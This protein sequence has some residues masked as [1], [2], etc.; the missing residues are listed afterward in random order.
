MGLDATDCRTFASM[1]T[2]EENV[3][4]IGVELPFVGGYDFSGVV[5]DKGPEADCFSIGDEAYGRVPSGGAAAEYV[6]VYQHYVASKPKSLS[7]GQAATIPIPIQTAHW[8]LVEKGHLQAGQYLL[9][10]GGGGSVGSVSV[11]LAKEPGA[12]AAATGLAK[13]AELAPPLILPTLSLLP[14]RELQQ[15]GDAG[16]QRAGQQPRDEHHHLGQQPRNAEGLVDLER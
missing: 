15:P 7:Y 1:S 4:S 8:F 5:V 6:S 2:M 9:V 11:M 10:L 3:S 16:D 13:H 14:V 12:K